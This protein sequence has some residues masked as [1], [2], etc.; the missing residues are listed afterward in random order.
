M[1]HIKYINITVKISD[2]KMSYLQGKV[3]ESTIIAEEF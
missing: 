3:T 1:K 2:T